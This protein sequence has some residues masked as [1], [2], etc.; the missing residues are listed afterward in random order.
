MIW[1]HQ[2]VNLNDVLLALTNGNSR[3]ERA[4]RSFEFVRHLLIDAPEFS[5]RVAKWD[6]LEFSARSWTEEDSHDKLMAYHQAYPEYYEFQAFT[7]GN[8]TALS[9]PLQTPMPTYHTNLLVDFVT[10]MESILAHLIEH[11][12]QHALLA[13]LLDKYGHLFRY[14]QYPLSFVC[15]VLL[16]YHEAPTLR[17][18]PLIV[19]R[20]ARLLGKKDR[21]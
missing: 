16:Y 3:G 8:N 12:H 18:H 15:N 4:S 5:Q 20:I 11:E 10:C 17:D 21:L 6:S 9:P 14:H 1:K 7:E 19:K 13:E 2:W